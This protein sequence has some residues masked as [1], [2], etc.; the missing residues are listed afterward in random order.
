MQ[1][2]FLNQNSSKIAF[3]SSF[4]TPFLFTEVMLVFLFHSVTY[5][6]YSLKTGDWGLEKW[7]DWGE[8]QVIFTFAF[9]LHPLSPV[10]FILHAIQR[11]TSLICTNIHKLIIHSHRKKKYYFYKYILEDIYTLNTEIHIK[12]IKGALNSKIDEKLRTHFPAWCELTR[13]HR[14]TKCISFW[15]R[16]H[17]IALFCPLFLYKATAVLKAVDYHELCKLTFWRS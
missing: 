14:D 1:V 12:V 16:K 13:F 17:I 10:F 4:P 8:S 6:W 15:W 7:R 5:T 11:R 2:I 9:V 3:T